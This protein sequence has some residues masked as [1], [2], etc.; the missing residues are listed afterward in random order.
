MKFLFDMFDL[1]EESKI[2]LIE[3]EFMLS[4]VF[5]SIFKILGSDLS[6]QEEEI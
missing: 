5:T 4:T 6:V 2:S 1:N 3:L